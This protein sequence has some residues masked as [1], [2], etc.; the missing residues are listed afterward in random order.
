MILKSKI[1][2]MMILVFN[3]FAISAKINARSYL[4]TVI[5][6]YN[7]ATLLFY[8]LLNKDFYCYIL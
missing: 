6:Y 3:P 5:Y 8:N 7:F 1:Y 2:Y 4:L